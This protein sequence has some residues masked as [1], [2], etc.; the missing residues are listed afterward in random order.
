ML[1]S[2]RQEGRQ[3]TTQMKDIRWNLMQGRM[4]DTQQLNFKDAHTAQHSTTCGGKPLNTQR[5]KKHR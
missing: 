1:L 3:E 4:Q 5:T 2:A